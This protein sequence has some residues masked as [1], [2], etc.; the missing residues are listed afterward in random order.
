MDISKRS[1]SDRLQ[2]VFREISSP[3]SPSLGT[4]CV[5][6]NTPD[7][8]RANPGTASAIAS[9]TMLLYTTS[10]CTLSHKCKSVIN[11]SQT[12]VYKPTSPARSVT[13]THV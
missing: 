1:T 5:E 3:N 9:T 11:V 2:I 10:F 4:Y 6:A 12:S 13:A 7:P 8:S